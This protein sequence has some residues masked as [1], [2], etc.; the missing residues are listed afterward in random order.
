M[1]LHTSLHNFNFFQKHP[2]VKYVLLASLNI[3]FSYLGQ[4]YEG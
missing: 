1:V 3:L 2:S 4:F